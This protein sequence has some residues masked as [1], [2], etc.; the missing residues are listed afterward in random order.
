MDKV[1]GILPKRK[2]DLSPAS[3]SGGG[4][5]HAPPSRRKLPLRLRIRIALER[6]QAVARLQALSCE[7]GQLSDRAVL[8]AVKT[9]YRAALAEAMVAREVC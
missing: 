2:A 3:V 9:R 6:H 4:R 1:A 5:G 8:E 7:A